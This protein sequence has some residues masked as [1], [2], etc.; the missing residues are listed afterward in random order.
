MVLDFIYFILIAI[1]IATYNLKGIKMQMNSKL[2]YDN[3]VIHKRA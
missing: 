3:Y 1:L 2:L